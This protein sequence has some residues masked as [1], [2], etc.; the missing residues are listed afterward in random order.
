MAVLLNLLQLLSAD[1]QQ[2]FTDKINFNFDQI[3]ALGGGPPGNQG[4]PG[5]QGVPGATGIQGFQGLPGQDGAKWYI[6]PNPPAPVS[7]APKAG[8]HW[9]DTVSLIIYE[10][11]GLVW[12]VVGTLTVN[13]VFKDSNNANNIIFSTPTPLKSLVLSS[14][15]YGVGNPQTGS[16]KLKLIGSS[17]QPQIRMGV[18]EPTAPN[19]TGEN[20][21]AQQSYISVS[22]LATNSEYTLDVINPTGHIYLGA[23]GTSLKLD[24]QV[25][26]VSTYEFNSND[27]QI[28]LSPT[29]RLLGFSPALNTGLKFHIGVQDALATT[30]S[31]L[32]TVSDNGSVG[33]GDVY[34]VPVFP[35]F[36]GTGTWKLDL[37]NNDS[38]SPLAATANATRNWLRLRGFV[39]GTDQNILE[40]RQSRHIAGSTS[41]SAEVRIERLINDG[42]IN[43]AGP[44]I[45]FHGGGA[46]GVT[47]PAPAFRIGNGSSNN[48]Y[49]SGDANGRIGIGSANFIK[50]YN[51]FTNAT[52]NH[53]PTRL[54]IESNVGSSIEGDSTYG[55]IHFFQDLSQLG[56]SA[57]A[58]MTTGGL[59][60][61]VGV[62][63]SIKTYA[64][65]MFNNEYSNAGTSVNLLASDYGTAPLGMKKRFT[66]QPNGTSTFWGNDN[67]T[68]GNALHNLSILT[69]NLTSVISATTVWDTN[70]PTTN[71][72]NGDTGDPT[73]IVIS[74]ITF[75]G[76]KTT[77]ATATSGT[78]ASTIVGGG[79]VGIGNFA[80]VNSSNPNPQTKFHVHGHA[81][82]GTRT[83]ISSYTTD[84]GYNTPTDP[85]S[86]WTFGVGHKANTNRGLILGGNGHQI[87]SSA[88]NS[89]IVGYNGSS[90][91]TLTGAAAANKIVMATQ[92][93]LSSATTTPYFTSPNSSYAISSELSV[94]KSSGKNGLEIR[95]VDAVASSA[96][97]LITKSSNGTSFV[98]DSASR[99]AINCDVFPITNTGSNG[100]NDSGVVSR[101]N[102]QTHNIIMAPESGPGTGT[103]HITTTAYS[104]A[105]PGGGVQFNIGPGGFYNTAGGGTSTGA[106]M[107]VRGGTAESPSGSIVGGDVLI[108]G[109]SYF[110][111]NTSSATG[112]V[113][114]FGGGSFVAVKG[115]DIKIVGGA[116]LGAA[117]T[118]G[119]VSLAGGLGTTRGVLRLAHDGTSAAGTVSVGDGQPFRR[120]MI[121]KVRPHIDGSACDILLG[122]GFTTNMTVSGAGMAFV[123]NFS[124]AFSSADLI[125]HINTR[126]PGPAMMQCTSNTASQ[127]TVTGS[128]WGSGTVEVDFIVYE[129]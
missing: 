82:F 77:T 127:I 38:T 92:T 73:N 9:F 99:V 122:S 85:H 76:N 110:G 100:W 111:T 56:A 102:V 71:G 114:I 29:D 43:T 67:N 53:F 95:N 121:G 89:V 64:G 1:D 81:T 65:V 112:G 103:L 107:I 33:I 16:Y 41:T 66:V 68:S 93:F 80:F 54:N 78:V 70:A 126:Y 49:F 6:Q 72:I 120:V 24:K 124:V 90:G 117:S 113:S 88:D 97:L 46:T 118:G 8:D 48:A 15:N 26:S 128:G 31:R 94:F 79:L 42:S 22:T 25:A 123:V 5:L 86:N 108:L 52:T 18:L 17:G 2:T 32:F 27:F 104:P 13:G 36:P 115:G 23:N 12:N 109:A 7:P 47:T 11:D 62:N 75:G 4:V 44:Y 63:P 21:T 37:L 57:N 19:G 119:H 69:Y 87:V 14:I 98:V 129:L 58:G 91:L 61:G 101:L 39:N 84:A 51:D 96:A 10:F 35:S 3:L 50:L 40:V 59:K 60:N 106:N 125:V 20:D 83:A 74:P 55:G 28:G 105:G 34:G 45:S 30:A 116:T